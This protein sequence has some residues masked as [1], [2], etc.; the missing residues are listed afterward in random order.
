[1]SDLLA[2][3]LSFLYVFA[4]LGAAEV[5]RRALELPVEF[6]RKVVH[7]AVGMWAFGTVAL[8][9]S[10]WAAMAPPLAFVVLNYISYRRGT[11][12]AM[13][14][15]EKSNLGTVYF[16]LAFAAMIA[17]FFEV[18]RS[19]VVLTLMP[20]T[21]GDAFAAVLGRRFGRHRYTVF[22]ATRSLEGSAAMFVFAWLSVTLSALVFGMSPERALGM[23]LALA[24]VSTLA[25]AL[26]VR[27][28][29]NLLVPAACA[30]VGWLLRSWAM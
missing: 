3:A 19:L 24:F 18:S 2:I 16:P 11:F 14:T 9:S 25:E 17:L 21:W 23:G 12:A 4:V 27:G 10:R 30:V 5:L 28:L 15:G 7:V 20:M 13:E 1:M 26:S 22:G 29:D 6:T 8:F